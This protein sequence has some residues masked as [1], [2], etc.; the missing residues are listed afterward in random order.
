[1]II[2]SKYLSDTMY[3]DTLEECKHYYN[4][5]ECEDLMDLQ[6]ALREEAEGMAYPV[7]EEI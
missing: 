4:H 6:D 7:L 3:F 5:E 1:M 2:K